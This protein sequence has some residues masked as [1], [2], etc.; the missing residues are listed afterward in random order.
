MGS[1]RVGYD[2]ACVY[3]T[4]TSSNFKGKLEKEMATHSR[5]LAWRIPGTGEPG[6]LP[7]V[8]SYRVGHDWSDLVVV[9]VR[10]AFYSHVLVSKCNS[11]LMGT[12]ALWKKWLIP[13]KGQGKYKNSPGYLVPESKEKSFFKKSWNISKDAEYSLTKLPWAKSWTSWK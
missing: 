4:V 7:S 6:G 9:E 2:F 13:G 10:S 12:K 1:Q 8:G 3:W 11:P 5:V